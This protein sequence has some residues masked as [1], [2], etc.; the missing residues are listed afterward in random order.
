[1]DTPARADRSA[2][3]T[4]MADA[5]RFLAIDAVERAASGHPGMPMGM[6]D[7]ATVL[8]SRHL[9]FDAADPTWPDRDRF[10]LSGGHGSMLLYALLHLTGYAGMPLEALKT[11][12]AL[13]S[14]AAGH[15]EYDVAHGI[16]MTTG[17]LG[18]GFATAVGMALAERMAAARFGADLVDHRTWVFCGDGDLMEG[19]SHEAASLAG[20]LRLAKLTVIWDDNRISID[21]ATTIATSDDVAARFAAYGWTVTPV[22]GHDPAALDA[23]FAAAARADR[24]TL[25][26]A[27]T[28]IGFGAP[29]KAGTAAAHGAPL[30]AEEVAATRA[31]LGWTHPPFEVPDDVRAAWAAVGRRG[32]VA[33]RAWRDRL[34]AATPE[35]RDA[36]AAA[37]AGDLAGLEAA[38]ADL[39]AELVATRPKIATRAASGKV[40]DRLAPRF[41]DLVG[42][43]ADLTPSNNTRFAGAVDVA[44]GAF[45]GRYIHY[46]VREGAMAAVMNGLALHGLH[47][48]Y[49]GTFLCFA[50]YARPGI[51]LAALMG[52]RVVHV[53][54][55]DSIGL[56]EDGPTHQPVEH[57]ASLRAMPN[58]NVF[59]PA[60]AVETAECWGLA[61]AAKTTPSVM[62][63]SRHA[64]P[65]L[66][67]TTA[68]GNRS[69]GGAY[70][71]REAA[72]GPR[73]V[74][75]VATG[76][77]VV[78]AAEAR[79]R[80]EAAG[81][82]TALVS[83]PCREL[84][85]ARPAAER[86][87]VLGADTL[88]VGVEAACRFGWG[89]LIGPDGIF[90]GMPGFGASGP[91]E[92][93]Y[94]RFGIT[95]EAI[96]AAVT[97]RL[98]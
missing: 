20:H 95:A 23:A 39:V 48:P 76:S 58:L 28:T 2:L 6:A 34:A 88:K 75:L 21:G 33:R 96:V 42:G 32:D 51:R 98:G 16:E 74:T 13:G 81:I 62:A 41:P 63:L 50:D 71:L 59:R 15:P 60:D 45:A 31:A 10:V 70:L 82:G 8:F 36:F 93:L 38:I 1:M 64:L 46:G 87:A 5:L 85:E 3:S 35:R 37:L 4:R 17:P 26:A 97:A 47:V 11:F 53:A 7:V 52:I 14:P 79:D 65:T 89:D 9:R 43:S 61:L 57:L 49:G 12:R 19:L 55:H 40:L 78:I 29:K 83:M 86:A 54:T 91:A 30:G 66:R 44:P 80:L 69:A 94:L 72:V 84:F 68:G 24:P 73:R 56:G 92:D 67:E 22:D 25:I 90:V 77:E 27:R 18:Q